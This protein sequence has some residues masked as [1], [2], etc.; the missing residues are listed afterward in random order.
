[1]SPI[2]PDCTKRPSMPKPPRVWAVLAL[3]LMPLTGCGY[4][5]QGRVV[6]GPVA[7]I[8][9]VD[10]SDPRLT[11]PN[12]TGGGAVIVGL[13][14]PERPSDRRPLGKHVT[15]RQGRFKIPVDA[16]GSGLLEYE[17]QL[18]ARREG[19]QAA[20]GTIPLPR[21]GERV[22][23]T[24]PLGEDRLNVPERFLDRALREAEPYLEGQR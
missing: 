16:F 24:L 15:D 13:L 12:L 14:E 1:M 23:I 20:V 8:T 2:M 22:L 5:I 4:A 7:E 3:C 19:H 6:R 10:S 9:V 18:I 21:R 11:E 17:A